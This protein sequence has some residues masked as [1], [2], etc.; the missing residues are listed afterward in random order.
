MSL[1]LS[2]CAVHSFAFA[3]FHL[4]FWKLFRWR[5]DLAKVSPAS[6]AI[7]QIANLR[8]I[9]VFVAVGLLCLIY[10]QELVRT[11]VGRAVLAGASLF[12]IGRLVEQFVFLRVRHP[13]VHALSAAFACGAV[14]FALPLV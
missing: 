1:T 8:L 2:L 14:L 3:G 13:L 5:T 10:P 12:W 6:R 4:C 11:S 9:Y 7:I